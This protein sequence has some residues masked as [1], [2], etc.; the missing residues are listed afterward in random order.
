MAKV[1][2]EYKARMEGM[3]R[4]L[5]IAKQKGI[6]GLEKEIRMRG[7]FKM[8][9]EISQKEWEQMLDF[10]I[11]NMHST[12]T[13]VA[14]ITLHDTFG[15]GKIRLKRFQRAFDEKTKL[16]TEFDRFGNHFVTLEDYAVY[17][18]GELGMDLDVERVAMCQNVYRGE[19]EKKK[20]DI[21]K[22]I[23]VLRDANYEDAAEFLRKKSA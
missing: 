12:Y 20:V 13:T 8:A 15:F 5:D 4:A 17:L 2:K 18:K 23:E 21:E 10:L 16:A 9:F 14:G 3:M 11:K 1:D 22:I 19:D 6:E 7:F